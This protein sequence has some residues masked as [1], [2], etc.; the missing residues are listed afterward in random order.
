MAC[1]TSGY[2][3]VVSLFMPVALPSWFALD[4]TSL[5]STVNIA[6][7]AKQLV[8]CNVAQDYGTRGYGTSSERVR[9]ARDK[10]GAAASGGVSAGKQA[11]G[12]AAPVTPFSSQTIG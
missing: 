9:H 6:S 4:T 5:S 2:G 12:W 11:S 7:M 1:D 8:P 3:T 10:G